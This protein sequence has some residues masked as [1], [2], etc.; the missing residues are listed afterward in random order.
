MN[1]KPIKSD[2]AR[3]DRM[4]DADIDYSDIPPLDRTFLKKATVAWPP[5]K[6]QVTIRLDADVLD[7]LKGH[8][9]GYQTRIN[10]ILRVVMESQPPARPAH[11]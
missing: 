6:Q 3:I 2:L 4:R 1:K 5:V 8:G 9:R 11:R 10:R 7:W